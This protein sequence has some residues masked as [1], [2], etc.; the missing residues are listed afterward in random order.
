LD[1]VVARLDLVPAFGLALDAIGSEESGLRAGLSEIDSGEMCTHSIPSG[2]STL[3]SPLQ[4]RR[5]KTSCLL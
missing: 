3:T 4:A 2:W 5:F 1:A